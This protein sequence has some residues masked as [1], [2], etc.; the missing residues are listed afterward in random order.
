MGFA[1]DIPTSDTISNA[2]LCWVKNIPLGLWATSTPR[3]YCNGPKSFM[4]KQEEK[5]VLKLAMADLLFPA[6]IRSSTYT[7]TCKTMFPL[8]K[9]NSE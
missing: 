2:Y 9:E 5:Y 1:S 8:E 6:I 3:K 4:W 7:S